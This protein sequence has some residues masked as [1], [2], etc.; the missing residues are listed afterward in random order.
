VKHNTSGTGQKH[1]KLYEKI[2]LSVKEI[3]PKIPDPQEAEQHL[4]NAWSQI[5]SDV[6]CFPLAECYLPLGV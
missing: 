5:S 6:Y 1:Q 3:Q 2:L 4:K